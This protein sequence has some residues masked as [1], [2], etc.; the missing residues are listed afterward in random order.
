MKK[1]LIFG[2]C[3][4]LVVFFTLPS[5]IFGEPGDHSTG[6]YATPEGQYYMDPSDSEYSDPPESLPSDD[7]DFL[8]VYCIDEALDLD[9]DTDAYVETDINVSDQL[10]ADGENPDNAVAVE[11][12]A[13]TATGASD[14]QNQNVVWAL[15]T[16]LT[17]PDTVL[18]ADLIGEEIDVYQSVLDLAEEYND[19]LGDSDYSND[20]VSVKDFLDSK[21]INDIYVLLNPEGKQFIESDGTANNVF[22][23]VAIMPEPLVPGVTDGVSVPDDPVDDD[24]TPALPS[25][26]GKTVTWLILEGS[27]NVSFAEDSLITSTSA[28]MFDFNDAADNEGSVDNDDDGMTDDHYGKSVIN[29]FFYWWGDGYPEF[30]EMNVRLGACVDIDE[31]GL[32]DLE[33]GDEL[34]SFNTYANVVDDETGQV[35]KTS[36]TIDVGKNEVPAV[37][38][39]VPENIDIDYFN[40]GKII[41]PEHIWVPGWQRF[42]IES[43]SEPCNEASA[44]YSRWLDFTVNKTDSSND[45]PVEGAVYSLTYS[46]GR[47]EP[48]SYPYENYFE[49]TTDASGNAVFTGLPWAI[50][51]L[52]EESAPSGYYLDTNVYLVKVAGLYG[53][54]PNDPIPGETDENE[55]GLIYVQNDPKTPPPPPPPP[56]TPPTTTHR[57][58]RHN[59]SCRTCIYRNSPC[60]SY[61]RS[62]YNDRWTWTSNNFFSQ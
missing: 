55:L 36:E 46:S 10:I 60:N 25:E 2:I 28:P 21:G 8:P 4:A 34:D 41:V 62:R 33:Q 52:M 40:S 1:L 29:Y 19:L 15:L 5:I 24:L 22:E 42:V 57:C 48:N 12:M 18:P 56:E 51:S 26:G 31:D 37:Q 17:L 7:N 27:Y 44:F 47:T 59:R 38:T 50:Y 13:T 45:D 53:G 16:S 30:E 43:Y 11:V 39:Y 32:I 6:E 49:Q 3:L 9:R 35:I 61:S 14:T 23:A 20:P 54:D 58:S